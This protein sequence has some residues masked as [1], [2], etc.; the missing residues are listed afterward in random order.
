MKTPVR[1][2]LASVATLAL[3]ACAP[4]TT[5]KPQSD[6]VPEPR[7]GN[8]TT[9]HSIGIPP[10]QLPRAGKCR[11]WI[12]EMAPGRQAHERSC[13]D[14][15]STAGP[16]SWIIYRNRDDSR[17]H[18]HVMDPSRVGVIYVVRYYDVDGRWLRDES[19]S[20][21]HD[22]ADRAPADSSQGNGHGRRRN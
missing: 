15:V 12:P 21:H 20:R 14:I 9:V 4:V 3:A 13:T 17:L 10:G 5:T 16:G 1:L 22:D 7:R 18:V 2:T 19:G 6:P 11:V 8:S